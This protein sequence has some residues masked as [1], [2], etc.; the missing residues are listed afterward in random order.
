MTMIISW[1][2]IQ[3]LALNEALIETE[4]LVQFPPKVKRHHFASWCKKNKTSLNCVYLFLSYTWNKIFI[5]HRQT[6]L[7][8][9]KSCSRHSKTYKFIRKRKQKFCMRTIIFLF[10]QQKAKICRWKKRR[11]SGFQSLSKFTRLKNKLKISQLEKVR[12]TKVNEL[13][14]AQVDLYTEKNLS[15]NQQKFS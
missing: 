1:Q 14:L 8:V 12:P 3:C 11:Q 2:L 6:F 10:I 9:V 15:Q 13:K 4:R 7:K 5:A